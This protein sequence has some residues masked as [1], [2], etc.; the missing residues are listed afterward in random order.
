MGK[1]FFC[2]GIIIMLAGII[3]L[4]IPTTAPDPAGPSPWVLIASCGAS[5]ASCAAVGSTFGPVGIA[6]GA[7]VGIVVGIASV[8]AAPDPTITV[9]MFPVWLCVSFI[10]V[11]IL[12][13]IGKYIFRGI[14]EFFDFLFRR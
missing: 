1:I 4:F 6:T 14:S 10:V 7:I 2:L 9:A 12:F 13:C 5:L 11:G 3:M 8:A